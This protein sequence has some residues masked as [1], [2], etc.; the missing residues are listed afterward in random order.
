MRVVERSCICCSGVALVALALLLAS[1]SYAET[2]AEAM[3]AAWER[4]PALLAEQAR[5]RAADH[6]IAIAHAGFYPDVNAAG[7]VVSSDGL[8]GTNDFSGDPAFKYSIIAEQTLFD[9]FRTTSTVD[10]ALAGSQA[11]SAGVLDVERSVL[12]EAVRVYADVLRD[13]EIEALRK[14]DVKMFDDEVKA[15]REGLANGNGTL[16]DVAQTRARRAQAMADLIAAMAEAE[17][18]VAEYE[19]VVGHA[20]VKLK[21][22]AIPRALLPESLAAALDAAEQFDPA[23][24]RALYRAKASSSAIDRV[25]ADALPQLKA[26]AGVDGRR[27]L[28]DSTD[29][30][31]AAYVGLRLSVPLFDGGENGAR[32]AQARELSIALAEDA[33]GQ[34]ERSR[35]ATIAAWRRL[36]AIRSRLVSEREAVALSRDALASIR[37]GLRLGQRSMIEV[38]DASREVLAAE[39]RVRL[40]ERDLLVAAYTLLAATGALASSSLSG[41][42]SPR[43]DQ[44]DRCTGRLDCQQRGPRSGEWLASHDANC[45]IGVEELEFRERLRASSADPRRSVIARIIGSSIWRVGMPN[46][47][48]LGQ[49][50]IVISRASALDLVYSYAIDIDL[51]RRVLQVVACD[52]GRL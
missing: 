10:E 11:A 33:R 1:P 24:K 3:S 32:V 6:E 14:R 18:S 16:T 48:S 35:A 17:V 39:V 37:E 36:A 31:D 19:R 51:T 30:R 23:A 9:G 46:S 25:Q 27:G 5:K 7:E 22:P 28:S 44:G 49:S 15:A 41:E 26:R 4:H 2:L 47:C 21:R 34:K 43:R 20:P 52:A 50:A 42:T 29:D 8:A 45:S 12:L 40:I 38:L 13:R